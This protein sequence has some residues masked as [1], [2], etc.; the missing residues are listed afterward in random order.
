[1]FSWTPGKQPQ[2]KAAANADQGVSVHPEPT[3]QLFN[4]VH[5]GIACELMKDEE[6]V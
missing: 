5:V 2:P 1:M 3:A 6:D 4:V